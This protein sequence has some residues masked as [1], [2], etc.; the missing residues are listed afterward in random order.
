MG[1]AI[2][3]FIGIIILMI[4]L[5]VGWWA[6]QRLMP[7]ISPYIPEPFATIIHV[8]LVVVMVLIV[9]WVILK[10]LAVAGVAVPFLRVDL[11]IPGGAVATL[12]TQTA[13]N[14]RS[15]LGG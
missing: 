5:A 4:L 8:L 10:I 1:A 7:L 2:G 6:I 9:L 13:P 3:A 11:G 14:L 15:M 12:S